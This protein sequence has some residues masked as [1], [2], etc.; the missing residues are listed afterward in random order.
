M[1]S[2]KPG[3]RGRRPTRAAAAV[4]EP[5]Y[6]ACTPITVSDGIEVKTFHVF[7]TTVPFTADDWA[8]MERSFP[9]PR[10]RILEMRD[11]LAGLEPI[12]DPY[13]REHVNAIRAIHAGLSRFTEDVPKIPAHQ[14]VHEMSDEDRAKYVERAQALRAFSEKDEFE[15]ERAGYL[16]G[17]IVVLRDIIPPAMKGRNVRKKPGD[18][19]EATHYLREQRQPNESAKDLW[20]RLKKM[21]DGAEAPIFFDGDQMFETKTTKPISFRAFE[22]RLIQP[23]PA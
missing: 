4:S 6:N 10:D 1:G 5:K 7:D 16:W 22:K 17:K 18:V 23:G 9:S 13:I 21:L 12:T 20:K 15:L 11:K 2:A 14:W 3:K 19:S 8:A